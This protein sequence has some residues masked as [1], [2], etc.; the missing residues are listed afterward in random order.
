MTPARVMQPAARARR[1]SRPST[2]RHRRR[3][4]QVKTVGDLKKLL[5]S[6]SD[7]LLVA[8]IDSEGNICEYWSGYSELDKFGDEGAC[9][10]LVGQKEQP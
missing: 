1:A 7:D 4:W 3:G 6:Q 2:H 9:I 5:A 10:L 8:F